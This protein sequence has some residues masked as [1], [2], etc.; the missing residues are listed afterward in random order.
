MGSL[1][2]DCNEAMRCEYISVI[3]HTSLP[4][5]RQI[6]RTTGLTL[7]PQQEVEENTGRV[8]YYAIKNLEELICITEGKH[9]D[10]AMGFAQNL[11]QCESAMQVN[12]KK[13]KADK[14]PGEDL[15]YVYGIVTTATEWFFIRFASDGISCTSENPLCIRFLMSA[16]QKGHEEELLCKDVKQVVEVIVGLLKDRVEVENG[17]GV[18]RQR[19]EGEGKKSLEGEG[20]K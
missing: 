8:D 13:R 18:K 14:T 17:T 19:V 5:A 11:V 15:D 16:L 6:T 20:K 7:S 9:H 12:K 3:L 1:T 10:V 2:S 4:I